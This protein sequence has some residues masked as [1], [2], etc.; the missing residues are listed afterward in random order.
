MIYTVDL[1]SRHIFC[2]DILGQ[3]HSRKGARGGLCICC[4]IFMSS[5]VLL[6][7]GRASGVQDTSKKGEL[8]R[9]DA[10]HLEGVATD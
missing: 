5:H 9:V 4:R 3:S 2:A 7:S 6:T 1:V 8:I 10:E